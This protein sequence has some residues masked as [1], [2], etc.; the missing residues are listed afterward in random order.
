[1]K[2]HWSPKSPFV[3]KVMIAAHETGTIDQI[4][5][6]RSV[7][8]MTRPNPTL[9][10]DNPVG[11]IPALVLDDGVVIADSF[12][13]CVYLDSLGAGRKIIPPEGPSRWRAFALHSLANGLL[14]TMILWRNERDRPIERQSPPHIAGFALKV[15]ACLDRLEA[16]AGTLDPADYDIGQICLG[17]AL[18]YADFRFADQAWRVGRPALASWALTFAARPSSQATVIADDG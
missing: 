6:T 16:Q 14:D 18:E 10:A 15:S 3:R 2:L 9:M 1:M 4:H 17:C 7:A 5:K 13:I 12:L 11:R 8:A